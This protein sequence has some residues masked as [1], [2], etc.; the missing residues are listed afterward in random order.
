[1]SQARFEFR[2]DGASLAWHKGAAEAVLFLAFDGRVV[3]VTGPR[4]VLAA[5]DAV[6]RDA[7]GALWLRRRADG[8]WRAAPEGVRCT[9]W[10]R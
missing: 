4:R 2:T 7:N 1:M 6:R 5:A 9:E 10:V 8:Q 3:K